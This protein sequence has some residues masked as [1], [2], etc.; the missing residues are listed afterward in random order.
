MKQAFFS[1][2]FI[3][4]IGGL[5]ISIPAPAKKFYKH[6]DENG[7]VHYSDKKPQATD[8]YESWQVRVEDSQ[9]KATVVNRG[10]DRMPL[11]YAIN[12]YHGPISV[13]LV[14]T[15]A[16]NAQSDPPWPKIYDVPATTDYYLGTIEA[17]QDNKS[18][19]YGYQFSYVL[20]QNNPA[21]DSGYAYRLPYRSVGGAYISQGFAG[22]FSHFDEQNKYAIDI[23]L[24][25]GT[26]VVAARSGVVMDYAE[27]F[28]KG[29]TEQKNLFR[30][31]YVRIAH[32]DGSMGLYAHLKLESVVVGNGQRVSAGQK[33]AESGDTGFSTGPHLHFAI[34]INQDHQLIAVPFKLRYPNGDVKQPMPGRVN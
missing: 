15:K 1:A 19:S 34:Q 11:L 2:H 7:I 12:P 21:Y 27:D 4:L 25:E 26:E 16:M 24:A 33:L 6:V 20:G 18:W 8:D 9:A 23:P 17:V 28:I 29:G 30:N 31:N 5:I 10:T 14:M 13:Q 22:N 32:D 3:F